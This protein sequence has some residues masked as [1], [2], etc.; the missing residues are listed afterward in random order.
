MSEIKFTDEQ[1]NAIDASGGSVLVSAAAGSGKTRVLVNR[2][3]KRMTDPENAI[4]ADRM[5]I[6]TFTKASAEEMKTRIAREIENRLVC[7]P[8]S[9]DRDFLL[10]QQVLLSRADISTVHGFCSK[11]IREN[12]YLLD[13]SRDFRIGEDTEM[14]VIKHRL[15]SDIIEEKYSEKNDAFMLLSEIVSSSKNDKELENTLLFVY[16]KAIAH[17]FPE[18]WLDGAAAMYDPQ[19]KMS[20]SIFARI[21]FD[22]LSS[23]RDF[24]KSQLDKASDLISLYPDFQK[25]NKTSADTAY[26]KYCEIYKRLY[27]AVDD[28]DLEEIKNVFAEYKKPVFKKPTGKAVKVSDDECKK[29][30]GCFDSIDSIFGDKGEFSLLFRFTDEIYQK[31]NKQLYPVVC[32]IRNIILD[33]IKRY[34]QIK[35]EHNVF[36]YSDLE[37]LMIK[38]LYKRDGEGVLSKTNFAYGLSDCYDEIMVDEYQDTND[39]QEMIFNAVSKNQNNIFV[40]GDVKQSIY[41]FREA[42]PQIFTSRRAGC[43]KYDKNNPKFPAK[44]ILDKN[45][46]SRE[47]IIDSINFTFENVMSKRVGEIDYNEEER[48]TF[49]ADKYPQSDEI[50]AEI[51]IIENNQ[52][53]SY[54]ENEED[55]DELTMYQLE[56]MH[57]S[58]II[59]DMIEKKVMISDD[60]IQRP[61]TYGDFSILMRNTSTHAQI[62]SAVLNN[63][64]IPAY[65]AKPNSLFGCYEVNTVLSFLKSVDNPLNDIA[66]LSL[67]LCPVFGFTSDEMAQLK[68]SSD[69]KHIYNCIISYINNETV[70]PENMIYKKCIKFYSVLAEFRRLAVTVPTDRLLDTF[71]EKTGFLSA[72]CA[73]KNGNI[74]MKNIRKFM[75]FIKNCEN[76][77]RKGLT[78]FIRYISRLEENGTE[79]KASDLVPANSV[80]IMTIHSSKGLEFPICILAATNAKG[81]SDKNDIICHSHYGIGINC[82]DRK[83]MVKFY[84]FQRAVISSEKKREEKSEEMRILYVAMTRA[85]EKLIVVSTIKPTAKEN[86]SAKLNKIAQKIVIENNSK[87]SEYSAESAATLSDWLIMTALVHPSM[88]ELRKDANAENLPILPCKAKWKYVHVTEFENKSAKNESQE[89]IPFV[90]EKLIELMKER[91]LQKYRYEKRTLVPSKVSASG[92]AHKYSKEDYIASTVPAFAKKNKITA[93]DRGTATHKLLQLADLDNLSENFEEEREKLV[94]G[95][96]MTREE[97]D[98]IRIK[99]VRNFVESKLFKRMS[100]S[101]NLKKEYRFTVNISANDVDEKL[102]CDDNVILQGAIDC[103]FEENDG[104]V[105]VDYKT[106]RIKDIN[107]LAEKYRKQLELYKNAAEQ[108]SDKKVKECIIY[109]LYIGEDIRVL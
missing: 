93:A 29:L 63:S 61:V 34:Y 103:I 79:V 24:I 9:P 60:G 107:E 49:G 85:K 5:L 84:S 69:E 26:I 15:M 99:D 18:E 10:R 22:R 11:I 104:I 47:G 86:Y 96:Y 92:L 76:C 102:D 71:L 91:F 27:S 39:I 83:N 58:D 52:T 42:V 21:I 74:R 109:S 100:N 30:H 88:S 62:Y 54:S 28:N 78:S 68:T 1:Q 45:F 75:H 37:H 81:N 14:E 57:I 20:D 50:P 65:N 72:V 33:F 40:V 97:A 48:L 64:G 4:P 2:V 23:P 105:I 38:L 101:L 66:I 94:I 19:V 89:H 87:I 16:E 70:N 108:L 95:G 36:D 8:D 46:R 67:M 80:K 25:S 13:I 56:A 44:I 77:G 90:D 82:I 55:D 31:N 41:K 6:M 59:N 73:M 43:I 17:P 32:C 98:A 51:H 3:I 35:N 53:S 7:Q 106:D 12:F